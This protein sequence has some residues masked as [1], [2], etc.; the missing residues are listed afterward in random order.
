MV[1]GI[2]SPI[3]CMQVVRF[4]VNFGARQVLRVRSLCAMHITGTHVAPGGAEVPGAVRVNAPA[5]ASVL[6]G[7]R[8][9]AAVS[10]R[11]RMRL[12]EE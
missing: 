12:P 5:T 11:A 10:R 6:R 2:T 1:N 3:H 8:K 7:D 4:G 9:P